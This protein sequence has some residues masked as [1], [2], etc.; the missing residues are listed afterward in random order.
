MDHKYKESREVAEE[1]DTLVKEQESTYLN[2][3]IA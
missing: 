3:M 1:R 2:T